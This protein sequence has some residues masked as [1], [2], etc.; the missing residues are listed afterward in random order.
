[1]PASRRD[2]ALPNFS[3]CTLTRALTDS[4]MRGQHALAKFFWKKQSPITLE[5]AQNTIRETI[6]KRLTQ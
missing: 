1:M 2:K 5:R 4:F 3:Y 6:Q